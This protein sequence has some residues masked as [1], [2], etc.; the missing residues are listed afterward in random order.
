MK[1]HEEKNRRVE[2]R[3]IYE[4]DVTCFPL[5]RDV[6]LPHAEPI[7]GKILDISNGG[8]RIQ[9][10]YLPV[11]VGLPLLVHV[12]I[13]M[14]NKTVPVFVLVR[15]AVECKDNSYQLGLMFMA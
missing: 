10:D 9:V 13:D 1:N 8:M 11:E 14:I 12:P 5:C 2:E 4:S 6:P 7:D 15:W 3:I